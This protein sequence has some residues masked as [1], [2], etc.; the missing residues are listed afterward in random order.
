MVYVDTHDTFV[1][2]FSLVE[3]Y[4]PDHTLHIHIIR[5]ISTHM[6]LNRPGTK[7]STHVQSDK[8]LTMFNLK[9]V[10]CEYNRWVVETQLCKL[11]DSSDTAIGRA[12]AQLHL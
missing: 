6:P 9:N 5:F 2:F 4:T 10:S 11:R 1:S 12:C 7:S 8:V 3:L